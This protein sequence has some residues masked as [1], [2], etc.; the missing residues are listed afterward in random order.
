M[1]EVSVVLNSFRRPF[2]LEKQYNAIKSQTVP[3]KEIF[4]W[5]NH[6][7]NDTQF[8]FSKYPKA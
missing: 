7:E 3:A 5:K 2:S 8:D 4:M 6:P 1:K